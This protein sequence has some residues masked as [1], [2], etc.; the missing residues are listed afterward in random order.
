M[1][2]QSTSTSRP[3]KK[4][5]GEKQAKKNGLEK[6]RRDR[7][8]HHLER[9]SRLFRAPERYWSEKEVLSLGE[10]NFLID[11]PN[12]L[13]TKSVPAVSFLLYAETFPHDFVDVPPT[14]AGQ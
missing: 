4:A 9:T 7:E 14:T 2:H 6:G 10:I 8:R 12:Q 13:L 5:S 11:G 1:L 3:G